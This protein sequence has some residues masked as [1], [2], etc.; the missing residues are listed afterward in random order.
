ML[1]HALRRKLPVVRFGKGF[2]ASSVRTESE[3]SQGHEANSEETFRADLQQKLLR[4][5]HAIEARSCSCTHT[6]THTCVNIVKH[7]F[8]WLLWWHINPYAFATCLGTS[9]TLPVT[10]HWWRERLKRV[11]RL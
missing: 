2:C 5:A 1:S 7:A 6:H 8:V 3:E 10:G 4:E 9:W 11:C